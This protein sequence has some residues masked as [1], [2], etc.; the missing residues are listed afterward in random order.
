MMPDE[1]NQ[2]KQSPFDNFFS[3]SISSA[4]LIG[5]V[6]VAAS[7]LFAAHTLAGGSSGGTSLAAAVGQAQTPPATTGVKIA[8]RTGEPVLGDPNAPVTIYEF[9]DFQCPFCQ[10]FF[11]NTLPDL[12][13]KYI[14]TGKAKLIYRYFPLSFHVNAEIAA[15]AGECAN[16][17]GKFQAYHDALYTN[18][19]ADGTGLD[20]ASLKKYAAQIGL[21]TVTFDQCL[22]SN[23]T[24][25]IVDKDE[26][27]GSAAGV[28]GTPTFYINGTQ[29][30]G[31]EPASVF[32]QTIGAALKG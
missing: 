2:K 29:V 26:A 19:Q 12:M 32:E 6:I 10:S 22:D 11:Q 9:A 31:A 23:A 5:S 28:S 18:G 21:N 17:Q 14:N 24:K 16:E 15:E 27:I 1:N 20:S 3:N 8:D 7:I 13:T 25:S 4:I 30:V